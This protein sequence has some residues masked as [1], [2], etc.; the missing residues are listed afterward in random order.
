MACVVPD[1]EG[2]KRLMQGI[3]DGVKAGN[4]QLAHQ[5]FS[6]VAQRLAAAHGVDTLVMACTEIPLGLGVKESLCASGSLVPGGVELIGSGLSGLRLVDPAVYLARA[7]ANR[8]YAR[9][10]P[11]QLP[12]AAN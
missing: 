2:R 7:L 8:A 5:C 1:A 3:Y 4:L 9:H 11:H 12:C 6:K 10:S